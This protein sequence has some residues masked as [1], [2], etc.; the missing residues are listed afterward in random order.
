MNFKLKNRKIER[1]ESP[2][3]EISTFDECSTIGLARLWLEKWYLTAGKN[4]ERQ[5][6]R[7]Q[8]DENLATVAQ[9]KG[10]KEQKG[11]QNGY[12]MLMSSLL[13]G[14]L[15]PVILRLNYDVGASRYDQ[16][17]GPASGS[18]TYRELYE[19][20]R[21]FMRLEP[22]RSLRL[23]EFRP[24]LRYVTKEHPLSEQSA[25]PCDD[26][27]CLFLLGTT[28]AAFTYV[29]LREDSEDSEE[30]ECIGRV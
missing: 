2:M 4:A 26:S 20:I 30:Y 16:L 14:D 11:I 23:V 27:Q 21:K 24:W 5:I 12:I 22:K 1:S 13:N 9:L 10:W 19:Q 7:L 8:V 17:Y 6:R 28:I 18:L 3:I 29:H 15:D 25:L